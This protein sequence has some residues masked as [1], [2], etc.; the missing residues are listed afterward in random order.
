MPQFSLCR[1][2]LCRSC[3]RHVV[4]G[5]KSNEGMKPAPA[6]NVNF[7]FYCAFLKLEIDTNLHIRDHTCVADMYNVK[8]CDIVFIQIEGSKPSI[9]TH[10][11]HL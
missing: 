4:Y 9:L 10:V 11:R 2:L 8:P 6:C 5:K 7:A 3:N 1:I